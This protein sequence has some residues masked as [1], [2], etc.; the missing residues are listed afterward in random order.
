MSCDNNVDIAPILATLRETAG[1]S[2]RDLAR[3]AGMSQPAVARLESGRAVPTIAT[4]AR[5][6]RAAGF[7]LRLELTPRPVTDALIEAF[8]RDI[9]RTLL[10]ENLKK[11]VDQRIRSMA[12]NQE[13]FREVRRAV[14][15]AKRK[16]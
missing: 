14:R 12:E 7:E 3:R 6:A 5:L 4:L 10:R 16:K 13:A 1:L 9:D 8:K 15:T 11:T 2:Q